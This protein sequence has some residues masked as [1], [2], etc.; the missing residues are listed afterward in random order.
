MTWTLHTTS[1]RTASSLDVHSLLATSPSCQDSFLCVQPSKCS[2]RISNLYR[3]PEIGHISCIFHFL[4]ILINSMDHSYSFSLTTFSSSGKLLQIEYALNAVNKG[5]MS[6]GVTGNDM[7]RHSSLA[8]NG[9]VIATE[10]KVPT[11]LIEE[12]SIQKI[13]PLSEN[14]GLCTLPSLTCRCSLLWNGTRLPYYR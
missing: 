10:R 1:S 5:K 7:E 2:Q 8:T 3:F 13:L 6:V 12:S 9:V 4:S 14:I 11:I